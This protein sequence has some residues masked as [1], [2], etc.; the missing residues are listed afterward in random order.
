MNIN[1]VQF[2]VSNPCYLRNNNFSDYLLHRY[3][4]LILRAKA[5]AIAV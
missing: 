4:S 5:P 3:G 1:M 2:V